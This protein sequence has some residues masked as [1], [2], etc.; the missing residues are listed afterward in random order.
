MQAGNVD[1]LP[2]CMAAGFHAGWPRSPVGLLSVW[3]DGMQDGQHGGPTARNPASLQ[4]VMR[5][6]K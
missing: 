3:H 6:S 4:T 1:S 5:A 2:S